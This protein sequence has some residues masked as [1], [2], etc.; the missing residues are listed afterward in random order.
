[1]NQ[2]DYEV[3]IPQMRS[4]AGYPEVRSDKGST[5]NYSAFGRPRSC[6]GYH[7]RRLCIR[8]KLEH[9][10]GL[11]DL[12]RSELRMP[13]KSLTRALPAVRESRKVTLPHSLP[14]YTATSLTTLSIRYPAGSRRTS[15]ANHSATCNRLQVLAISLDGFPSHF[16][17]T[18]VIGRTKL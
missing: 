9:S 18:W 15:T 2:D 4:L 14:K 13:W 17:L 16:F 6:W 1:M 7:C 3:R 8:W 5:V 11:I 10:D 12:G